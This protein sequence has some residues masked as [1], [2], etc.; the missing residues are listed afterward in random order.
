MPTYMHVIRPT[1]QIY[2]INCM[3]LF[4][5]CSLEKIQVMSFVLCIQWEY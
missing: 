3:A 1:V 2:Q 5:C 4:V